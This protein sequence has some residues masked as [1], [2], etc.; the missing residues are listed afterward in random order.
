MKI[1]KA[2]MLLL[3]F[4]ILFSCSKDDDPSPTPPVEEPTGIEGEWQLEEYDYSGSSTVSHE[5]FTYT[6]SYVAV[7]KNLNVKLIIDTE[8]NTWSTEGNYTLELTTTEDGETEIREIV[9]SNL[10]NAG[11]FV[12][13]D[14]EFLPENQNAGFPEP[15]EINPMD[16]SKF[17]IKELTAT[18]LVLSFD[19]SHSTSENGMQGE[20]TVEGTQVYKRL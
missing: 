20:T 18:R 1:L 15:G 8:P 14:D 6:S 11:S 13:N 7:A 17:T 4:T 12:L 16:I 3:A 9:V 5:E 10:A 19:E 2:S